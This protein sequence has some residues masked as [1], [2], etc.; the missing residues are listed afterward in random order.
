MAAT[1]T[2]ARAKTRSQ[3]GIT[4][5]RVVDALT[6]AAEKKKTT[7]AKANTSQPRAKVATGRVSKK[8]A[9]KKTTTKNPVKKAATKV[10][11]AVEKTEGKVEGKPG[12]KVCELSLTVSSRQQVLRILYFKTSEAHIHTLCFKRYRPKL[13]SELYLHPCYQI[14]ECEVI[15]HVLTHVLTGS[16]AQRRPLFQRRRHKHLSPEETVYI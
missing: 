10:N 5:A 1:S 3:S 12:K 9:T 7:K 8:P 16:K 13:T 4:K 2:S 14:L 15:H 11:G 6:P